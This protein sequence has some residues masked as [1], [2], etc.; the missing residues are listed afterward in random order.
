MTVLTPDIGLLLWTIFALIHLA[1][2]VTAAI[3]LFSINSVSNKVKLIWF[4]ILFM[5]PFIGPAMFFVFRNRINRI[6]LFLYNTQ[7]TDSI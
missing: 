3:Q 4:A 6:R 5:I 1:M 2:L 7:I